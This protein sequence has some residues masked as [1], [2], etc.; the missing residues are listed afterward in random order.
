MFKHWRARSSDPSRRYLDPGHPAQL[1]AHG[2]LLEFVQIGAGC[3]E[4]VSES[5]TGPT[6]LYTGDH[7][8]H[9]PNDQ[10]TWVLPKS[11]AETSGVALCLDQ[12]PTNVF[13]KKLAELRANQCVYQFLAPDE[14]LPPLSLRPDKNPWQYQLVTVFRGQAQI[15][16]TVEKQEWLLKP[17]DYAFIS[18]SLGLRYALALRPDKLVVLACLWF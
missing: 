18:Q 4:C 12:T 6:H 11:Q 8:L 7:K 16:D 10:R 1:P 13:S 9:G 3:F 2:G 5:G 14:P 17:N 15:A